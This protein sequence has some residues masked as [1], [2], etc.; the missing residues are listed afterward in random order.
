M[1]VLA[2]DDTQA[3]Y[4]ERGL[5]T[6]AGAVTLKVPKLRRKTFDTGDHRAL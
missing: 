4:Y 2:K 1:N 5:N 6:K 3:V